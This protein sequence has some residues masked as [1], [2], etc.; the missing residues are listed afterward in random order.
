MDKTQVKLLHRVLSVLHKNKVL[1]SL[2]V[3]RIPHP[4]CFVLHKLIIISKRTDK[5]K[6]SKDIQQI[7]SLMH[8]FNSTK[9]LNTLKEVYGMLSKGWQKRIK[10]Q[11]TN[12]HYSFSDS[13]RKII[14]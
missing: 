11:L 10:I 4:A 3:I 5:G 1:D 14:T 12:N 9:E 8:F 2:I 13:I 7:E 6:A